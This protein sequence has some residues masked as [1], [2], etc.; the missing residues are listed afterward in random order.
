MDKFIT[1]A[2]VRIGSGLIGLDENQAKDRL[3]KLEKVADGIYRIKE[4]IEFKK[5]EKIKLEN[6]DKYMLANLEQYGCV[7]RN[8]EDA[9]DGVGLVEKPQ[10]EPP[11]DEKRGR[12]RPKKQ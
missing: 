9:P 8:P 6:P 10:I 3:R 11:P 12:G 5:G 7:I 1:N 2:L 4:L